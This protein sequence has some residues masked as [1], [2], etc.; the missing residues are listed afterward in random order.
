M[1]RLFKGTPEKAQDGNEEITLKYVA[2]S[3]LVLY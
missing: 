3:E 1:E 2:F